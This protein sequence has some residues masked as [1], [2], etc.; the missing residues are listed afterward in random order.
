MEP[1]DAILAK[2]TRAAHSSV[3]QFGRTN[4]RQS[5]R[6]PFSQNELNQTQGGAAGGDYFGRTNPSGAGWRPAL[7]A[8]RTQAVHLAP[9]NWPNEPK[10]VPSVD[11]IFGRTEPRD[12]HAGP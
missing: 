2:R 8:E 7:L 9:A 4:P 3:R 11:S 6:T 12:A 5:Q 1:V 10:T